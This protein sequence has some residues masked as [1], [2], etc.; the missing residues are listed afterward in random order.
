[1][2]MIV[3]VK[4]DGDD[5]RMISYI[6][7]SAWHSHLFGLRSNHPS[8]LL[9]TYMPQIPLQSCTSVPLIHTSRTQQGGWVTYESPLVL[10]SLRR[11][12]YGRA[13]CL[14]APCEIAPKTAGTQPRV[15]QLH[16]QTSNAQ[17]PPAVGLAHGLSR[18]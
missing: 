16:A 6:V 10:C 9:N 18:A 12:A 4:E 17:F 2:C 1:M 8:P 5:S 11:L 3:R 13:P 14:A 7:H 15:G